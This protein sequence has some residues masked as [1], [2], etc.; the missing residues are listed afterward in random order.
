MN[1]KIVRVATNQMRKS[2]AIVAHFDGKI[3][4]LTGGKKLQRDRRNISVRITDKTELCIPA[5]ER[6]TAL[7]QKEVIKYSLR[8]MNF[9][10]TQ[11][12]QRQEKS[13]LPVHFFFVAN[14]NI[15][16]YTF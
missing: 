12:P 5:I 13:M 10:L 1:S 15:I 6:G 9:Y 8:I 2:S 11:L 4:E 3:I 14:L 7:S 16:K